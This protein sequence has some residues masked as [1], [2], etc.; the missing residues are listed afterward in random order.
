MTDPQIQA[1]PQPVVSDVQA[2][3]DA[4]ASH[5]SGQPQQ[6]QFVPQQQIPQQAP[7]TE[8][9]VAPT[10]PTPDQMSEWFQSQFGV[11]PETFKAQTQLTQLQQRWNAT[12]QEIQERLQTVRGLSATLPPALQPML[13]TIDGIDFLWN[14]MGGQVQ[15]AQQSQFNFERN[16]TATGGFDPSRAQYWFDE[17]EILEMSKEEYEKNADLIAQAEAQGKVRLVDPSRNPSR[18]KFLQPQKFDNLR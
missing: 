10:Q 18:Y 12:P 14:T 4:V 11:A 15:Q 3:L 1:Q 16:S 7:V 6:P 8:Q 2:R 17:A 13:D 5:L 9:P